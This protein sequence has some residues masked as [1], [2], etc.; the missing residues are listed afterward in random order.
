MNLGTVGVENQD[1]PYSGWWSG[2]QEGGGRGE[3]SSEEKRDH[4]RRGDPGKKRLKPFCRPRQKRKERERAAVWVYG[5]SFRLCRLL[6]LRGRL[7]LLS[8][9]ASS[10]CRAPAA[11]QLDSRLTQDYAGINSW[12]D[13]I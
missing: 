5:G 1:N 11:D 10:H 3:T 8:V 9:S 4:Q 2:Q 6:D 12:I 7:C 13:H